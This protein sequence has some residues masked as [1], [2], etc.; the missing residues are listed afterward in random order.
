[1]SLDPWNAQGVA[2]PR[3]SPTRG[4]DHMAG[5][6]HVD[7]HRHVHVVHDGGGEAGECKPVEVFALLS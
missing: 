7:V 3:P 2:P 5:L 1:M 4:D 6:G